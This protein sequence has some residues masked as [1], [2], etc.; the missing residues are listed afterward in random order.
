M[1]TP[2]TGQQ[3]ASP[4][5]TLICFPAPSGST[6]AQCNAAPGHSNH[7]TK[8]QL[9]YHHYR[10]G[11]GNLHR[12]PSTQTILWF[13]GLWPWVKTT[14]AASKATS[15]PTQTHWHRGRGRKEFIYK[16]KAKCLTEETNAQ[17]FHSEHC[18]ACC[19]HQGKAEEG[20]SNFQCGPAVRFGKCFS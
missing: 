14:A 6:P 2:E 13:C 8:T 7:F 15:R 10:A 9:S 19:A 12:P 5:K 3:R 11:P 20:E 17:P 1:N 4:C 16:A 18:L